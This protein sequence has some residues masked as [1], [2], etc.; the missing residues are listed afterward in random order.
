MGSNL[1]PDSE[2]VGPGETLNCIGWLEF[3]SALIL[4]TLFL[5]QTDDICSHAF[6]LLD[7]WCNTVTYSRLLISLAH[8]LIHY[9]RILV[10]FR[11]LSLPL[12]CTCS[13]SWTYAHGLD[14]F[15]ILTASYGLHTVTDLYFLSLC[16]QNT[17]GKQSTGIDGMIVGESSGI[18]NMKLPVIICNRK[19][20]FYRLKKEPNEIISSN[21]VNLNLLPSGQP[22]AIT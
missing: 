12:V 9:S 14:V 10:C 5:H 4:N 11:S 19:I 20:D 6:T 13:H 1:V 21:N 7:E 16:C 8:A 3:H 22:I 17:R 15:T 18:D 2:W